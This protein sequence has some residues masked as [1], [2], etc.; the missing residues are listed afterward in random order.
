MRLD[1]RCVDRLQVR[2]DLN[3]LCKRYL[4]PL[5]D[6]GLEIV[7][8]EAPT[9]EVTAIAGRVSKVQPD[10]P[11]LRC[12]GVVDDA[13]LERERGGRP[14][15]YAGDPRL[16]DPAVVTLNGI[17]ASIAATEV[18]RPSLASPAAAHRT[19]DGSTTGSQVKWSV[20][21]NPSRAA[22]RRATRSGVAVRSDRFVPSH[23]DSPASPDPARTSGVRA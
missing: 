20:S 1:R 4:I 3:R 11:C 8:G 7:P 13:R 6:V 18:L 21:R 12:Q 9:R 15:G 2:D 17:V 5:V 14:A 23:D 16:P 19:V 22:V 10:G